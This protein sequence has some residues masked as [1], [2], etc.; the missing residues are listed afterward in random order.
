SSPPN[1]PALPAAREATRPYFNCPSEHAPFIAESGDP[2]WANPRG[3]YLG[4]IGAGNM[5]GSDPRLL[6]G[7]TNFRMGRGGTLR[8]VFSLNFQQSFD[9]PM[10]VANQ[11]PNYPLTAVRYTRIGDITDGTSNTI[12]AS[13]GLTSTATFWGGVQGTV[14]EMDVGGALF[15]T[16]T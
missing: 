3:N 10:D 4:C 12:M 16:F 15:S 8:G 5:Y 13:E 9:Y 2:D 14:E 6:T 7:D 1:P 11:D